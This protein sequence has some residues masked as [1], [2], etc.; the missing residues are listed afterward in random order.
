MKVSYIMIYDSVIYIDPLHG[1]LLHHSI[2][3]Y[4]R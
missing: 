4:A 3:K 2:R 1:K